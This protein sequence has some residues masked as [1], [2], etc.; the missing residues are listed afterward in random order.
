MDLRLTCLLFIN[1]RYA[2]KYFH[3]ATYIFTSADSVSPVIKVI[4]SG[5]CDMKS[6]ERERDNFYLS[7]AYAHVCMLKHT[8]IFGNERER[9]HLMDGCETNY[10]DY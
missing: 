8:A 2:Y 10:L 4:M 3:R 6:E 1:I 5:V 9:Y 7:L